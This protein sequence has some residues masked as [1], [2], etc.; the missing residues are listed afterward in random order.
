M[1]GEMSAL[2]SF[3]DRDDSPRDDHIVVLSGA[4]WAD[5]ERMLAMRGDRS[6]PRVTY[7]EGLLQIMS[8]SEPH[9]NLKSLIGRL[10]ETYCLE[11]EIEFRTLGSWTIADRAVERGAEPDECYVLRDFAAA[12]RPDLVIEVVWTS[13]GVNKLGVYAKLGV[14]E[15][16]FWRRGRITPFVLVGERYEERAASAALPGLDLELLAG[17]LDRPTTSAAI[18][19]YR[20]ALRAR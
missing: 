14:G 18:R 17:F 1:L 19:E 7:V 6:V 2:A 4:T 15:V 3:R 11:A 5:F 8:P 12:T 9:E 20:A 13:G 10:V 16:W